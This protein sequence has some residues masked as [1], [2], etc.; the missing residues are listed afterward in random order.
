MN[1]FRKYIM[2][3]TVS[4]VML[5]V[6]EGSTILGLT[7]DFIIMITISINIFIFAVPSTVLPRLGLLKILS[8]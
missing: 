1:V 7:H 2:R 5:C 8:Q 4:N 6:I 3:S